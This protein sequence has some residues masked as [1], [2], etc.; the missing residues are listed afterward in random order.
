[1]DDAQTGLTLGPAILNLVPVVVGGLLATLGV[2]AGAIV[3]HKL[4]RKTSDARLKREKLEQLVDASYRVESWLNE[5][6]SVDLSG[7]E[8][9]IGILPIS[10]VEMISRLYFPELQKEVYRLSVASASY[11]KWIAEGRVNVL[12]NKAITDEHKEKFNPIY[13]EML[14]SISALVDGASDVMKEI[15]GS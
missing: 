15:N 11:Q 7:H 13:T 3:V 6:M 14:Q 9:D 4:E 1:M 2:V 12:R 8:R 5:R 10:E